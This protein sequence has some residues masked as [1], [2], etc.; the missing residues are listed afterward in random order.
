MASDTTNSH[1]IV[2][3]PTRSQIVAQ[4]MERSTAATVTQ[5]RNGV[6]YTTL[7]PINASSLAFNATQSIQEVLDDLETEVT[8][9]ENH[10]V[11][12]ATESDASDLGNILVLYVSGSN[13]V[14]KNASK[15]TRVLSSDNFGVTAEQAWEQR[16]TLT[17]TAYTSNILP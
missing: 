7:T 5:A 1:V 17:Y 15:E 14:L 12:T 4:D 11:Y 3:R 8:L 9:L 6:T 16:R 2:L 10:R 13:W